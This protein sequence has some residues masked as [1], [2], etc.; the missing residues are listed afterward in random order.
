MKD[1]IS[2]ITAARGHGNGIRAT[3]RMNAVDCRKALLS[4]TK[5]MLSKWSVGRPIHSR[6]ALPSG[7]CT[8]AS[9]KTCSRSNRIRNLAQAPQSLQTPSKSTIRSF[10]PTS[11]GSAPR[12]LGFAPTQFM[13]VLA[14]T[15]ETRER[16]RGQWLR[17]RGSDGDQANSKSEIT[18]HDHLPGVSP[19]TAAQRSPRCAPAIAAY[20]RR[21]NDRLTARNDQRMFV[22]GRQ[23]ALGADEC[24]TIPGLLHK[25]TLR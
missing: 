8:D 11:G 4:S 1:G 20:L 9:L 17:L 3:T 23:I 21:Q 25:R 13:P 15:V 5:T 14:R 16:S 19:N 7:D 12:I 10:E 22:L 2:Q 24:P 6:M 18:A